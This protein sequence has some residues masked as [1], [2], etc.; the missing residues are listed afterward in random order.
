MARKSPSRG[1][2]CPICEVPSLRNRICDACRAV[3]ARLEN[4]DKSGDTRQ[5]SPIWRRSIG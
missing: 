3:K 5:D 1:G 4:L 2:R